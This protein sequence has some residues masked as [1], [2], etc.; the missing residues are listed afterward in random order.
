MINECKSTRPERK[1][2]SH[3]IGKKVYKIP[4]FDDRISKRRRG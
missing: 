3:K 2:Q 4:Y 1:E